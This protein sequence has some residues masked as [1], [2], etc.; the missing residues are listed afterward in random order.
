MDVIVGYGD[1]GSYG[2]GVREE[3]KSTPNDKD[4]IDCDGPDGTGEYDSGM[5]DAGGGGLK[6]KYCAWKDGGARA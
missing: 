3:G 2:E 1:V 4:N 6:W 5:G